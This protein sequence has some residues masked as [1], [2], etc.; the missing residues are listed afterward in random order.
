[1]KNGK[2]KYSSLVKTENGFWE[3]ICDHENK[4]T[5]FVGL[6]N[7]KIVRK[8]NFEAEGLNIYPFPYE[9]NLVSNRVVLF[10]S[11]PEEY[12]DEARLVE[13]I[14][15]FI[16]Q[17]LEISEFFEK[18]SPFYVLLSWCFES[19]K[20]LPY[21]RAIGDYGCGKS[22]FLKVLGSICYKPSF[23][24]GA[25]N[26]API[27]RIISQFKGTLVIDE[28]DMRFS[29]T[30]SE[31][32]KILNNGFQTGMPVLRCGSGDR[33]YEVESYDVFCPK[34]VATR[35]KYDDKALESRFLVEHMDGKLTRDDIPLNLE[36]SFDEQALQI[37][38]KCLLWRL[39]NY[40]KKT[41]DKS[42]QD[43]SIEARLNQVA[44]P[45][46]S[47]IE[48]PEI[49]KELMA[50]FRDYNQDLIT[51]RGFSFEAPILQTIIRLV[52]DGKENITVG[53]IAEQYN[54]S[55]VRGEKELNARKIG[56][57]I[58]E[59]FGFRS[60]R[61][62]IGHVLDINSYRKQIGRLCKKYGLENE[63]VN[64]VNIVGQSTDGFVKELEDMGLV[65]RELPKF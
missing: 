20:E 35:G 22:R 47:V 8:P 45:L 55:L 13:E 1:M 60:D 46:I 41:I 2:K 49:K 21:L 15:L 42:L 31:V 39:R 44:T 12:G 26:P 65:E 7:E 64:V 57:M 6:E 38:N 25:T 30:N 59:K 19:F 37:R 62:N 34:I 5:Y 28:A 17:Y 43:R 50:F 58:R 3:M 24:A 16:H 23:T 61:K 14:R 4:T 48:S 53:L 9:N 32:V 18:I 63:Q 36:D 29:D 51:D 40:G 27:F 52:N 54:M 56:S 10:P 11:K 33:D